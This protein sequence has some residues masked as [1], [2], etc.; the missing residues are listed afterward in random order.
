M[1]ILKDIVKDYVIK[2]NKP[3]HAL[4]NISVEFPDVGFVAILGPSG[5][6]KTTLLNIIGGLD[7]YTSGDVII[8]GQSTKD[9]NDQ[10]WDAYRNR[11]I[12]I[13]FQSYNLI[14]HL[15]VLENVA[16]ALTLSGVNRKEREER[17]ETALKSVGL[18]N[19]IHKKPNQLSGG[20]MQ[21]VA[22]ARAIVNQPNIVLA[23]EPTGALD[24]KTSVQVMEI[25][26][27]IS[28]TKLVIIV[29][30]NENL[31]KIYASRII[32]VKDG[33]IISDSENS[34]VESTEKRI[35]ET[36]TSVPAVKTKHT[37]MSF[38]TALGISGR[39][40]LT[41]KGKTVITSIAASFG[42]IGVGLVLALSNGFSGYINRM[43]KETLSKF[44]L[45]IE[46]YGLSSV[47]NSGNQLE[48][49]PDD[50]NINVIEPA[51]SKLHVNKI[52]QEYV[53][54]LNTINSDGK[55]YCSVRY[56]YSIDMKVIGKYTYEG[57]DVYKSINTTQSSF[58]ESMTSAMSGTGSDWQQLPANKDLI[59]SEYDIIDAD[60]VYPD[61]STLNY[62]SQGRPDQ[63]EFGLVLVV[64]N[65]NAITTTVMESLGLD[66]TA[67]TY[68]FDDIKK[69]TEFKYVLQDDYYGD[70]IVNIDTDTHEAVNTYGLF[71]K[72]N[73]TM[74]DIYSVFTSDDGTA[75]LTKLSDIL[76]LP[77]DAELSSAMKETGVL[78]ALANLSEYIN[79]DELTAL[80]SSSDIGSITVSQVRACFKDIV[81]T[82]ETKRQEC[83]DKLY[84]LAIA[85][86]DSDSLKNYFKKNL[87]YYK[88]PSTDSARLK[89]LYNNTND[90]TLKIKA[91]LRPKSTTSIGILNTG[92]YYPSSLTY[93]TFSDNYDSRISEDFKDHLFISLDS[94]YKTRIKS[95]LDN[96]FV[97]EEMSE[98]V[99]PLI[100][101]DA[102]S[103][104][105][106][107]IVNNCNIYSG[108][109]SNY[110]SA[111]LQLGTDFSYKS[112]S[113]YLD[114]STYAEFVSSI[115]IYPKDYESKQYV[116]KKLNAYNEDKKNDS[117]KMIVY[118][119]VGQTGTDVV[120]QIVDV[121]SSVLIAF[122][123]I[124]LIVSSVMIGIIIY[125]SVVERIKEIGVLRSIGARKKDV[126]RLFKA[127][128]VIIGAI[129]GLF[130]VLVTYLIS[131]P[132]SLILD[133]LYP[134][135][136]LGMIA[137]LN[138]LHAVLMV[139]ISMILTYIASLIPARIA[140]KKDPVTCLRTD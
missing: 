62:D 78:A 61:E 90:R 98:V 44:P 36:D 30:H 52:T 96:L 113:D 131:V 67:G 51:T 68:S 43:E 76:N 81:K 11:E 25:L 65:R 95:T 93:Q 85:L 9:Y 28:K 47:D 60:G 15:S 104:K 10:D 6:G 115:T 27:E 91:I 103:F 19:E 100:D 119:D 117:S 17:A 126:G 135:V 84:D 26:K 110:M 16:L 88:D 136:E 32:R 50:S 87:T 34:D 109:I 134:E 57:E 56:S 120:G 18:E 4:K 133:N 72:D 63:D 132:L 83:S 58:V 86:R 129:S 107:G 33:N 8:N 111:R 38:L 89:G 49:Y 12:G 13:V 55:E 69:N 94:N 125:S 42:I 3:T 82:D 140:A 77:S 71:F 73:L 112:G 122:A 41:K 37:S 101:D 45:S 75:S 40:L 31:A 92:I 54:Y 1:L 24:S 5:C 7:K 66:P 105:A 99:K 139:V 138:P 2:D 106:L 137:F 116:V 128:A 121:I 14:V 22:L 118:T 21:R 46:R 97:K 123:S 64:N 70:S 59:L 48:S 29:T 80:L 130:G 102:F 79:Q 108:G 124:S 35:E 20:Q 39:N 114:P 74:S 127:E 53:D 23:D